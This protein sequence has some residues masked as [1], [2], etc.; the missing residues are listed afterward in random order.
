ML[1]GQIENWIIFND[2]NNMGLLS[3]PGDT[4]KK[5]M[6]YFQNNYRGRLFKM[7]ILNAPSS[8]AIAWNLAKGLLEDTTVKKIQF[9]K[10]NSSDDMWKHINKDQV[11]T[12]YGGNARDSKEKFWPPIFPSNNYFTIADKKEKILETKENYCL[13]YKQGKLQGHK[14]SSKLLNS[15]EKKDFNGKN[16]VVN[17][18]ELD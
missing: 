12:K 2:L 8:I 15:V 1:P 10:S 7:Y 14:V 3:L 5:V 17:M 13:R 4:M 18:E 11:E 16:E 9:D 6:K